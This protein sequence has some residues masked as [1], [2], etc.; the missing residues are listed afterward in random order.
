M[1][2]VA[3]YLLGFW[4]FVFSSAFRTRWLVEFRDKKVS[5][6]LFSLF[7]AAI[8]VAIG[9]GVP[10][11]FAFAIFNHLKPAIS[12]DACLDSGGSYN[13]ESCSCDHNQSHPYIENSKCK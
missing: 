11:I 8:S 10:V 3:F 6:K 12:V 7:D 13:Y 9:A 4:R 5:E 1:D 2:E